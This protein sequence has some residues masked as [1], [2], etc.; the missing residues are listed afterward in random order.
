[1]FVQQSTSHSIPS[2]LGQEDRLAVFEK[3]WDKMEGR[4]KHSANP[5]SHIL[6]QPT[7]VP[8]TPLILTHAFC[9][10]FAFLASAA[11][12]SFSLN[13]P[14]LPPLGDPV[15]F[16]PLTLS[17]TLLLFSP[18]PCPS[19]SLSSLPLPRLTPRS[20]NASSNPFTAV[21]LSPVPNF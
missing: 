13:P 12:R 19:L 6:S 2:R 7:S 8:E 3:S 14:P 11:N 10:N 17:L 15:L 20:G 5:S 16:S 18:L 1:M 21:A 4:C 9:A